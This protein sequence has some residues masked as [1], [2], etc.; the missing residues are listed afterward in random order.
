MKSFCFAHFSCQIDFDNFFLAFLFQL[1]ALTIIMEALIPIINKLQDVFNT[2]GSEHI[3]LP[4]IVVVGSQSSGKSSVLESIVG[5]DFLPRGTGIV[6]RRPLILQLVYVSKDDSSIRSEEGT[7]GLN[8]WAKFLHTK[9]KVYTDF[10]EVRREIEME[11]DRLSGDNKGIC[12][13][14]INLKIYS[15]K[16]VNLT[17]IDLPGLTKVP[18]GDQPEDIEIQIRNLVLK[19]ISNPNSIILAVTAANTDFATSESLKLAREIDPDG[20]RTLAVITKLDL[21]DAGTGKHCVL[22]RHV[23]SLLLS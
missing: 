22:V 1:T 8:E 20:R 2:I 7:T 14:P 17:L 5:R 19:Y 6:T 21:M 16:V 11:T 10:N 3:L 4:Q 12:Q 18:V 13:D 15:T 23:E 9:G